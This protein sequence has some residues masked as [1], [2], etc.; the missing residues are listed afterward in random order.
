MTEETN[1]IV[2]D[3]GN[4]MTRAGFSGSE[5]PQFVTRS[6]IGTKNFKT[7]IGNDV[8]NNYGIYNIKHVFDKGPLCSVKTN[9]DLIPIIWEKVFHSLEANPAQHSV[10]IC[11]PPIFPKGDLEKTIE[12]MFETFN[13]PFYSSLDT[14]SLSLFTSGRSTG[15]VL[16]SGDL[17]TSFVPIYR[18]ELQFGSI[19]RIPLAGNE[20]TNYLSR[21]LMYQSFDFHTFK[22]MEIL[23]KIKEEHCFVAKD[24][25]YV[26]KENIECT[27]HDKIA[28]L[29][30][31]LYRCPELIFNPNFNGFR[32]DGFSKLLFDTINKVDE[33]VRKDLYA[34]IVLS[35]GN[36]MF[37]GFP[38]RIEKDIME[39]APPT[40]KI[41]CFATS[42]RLNY[43]WIGGSI[44]A[45]SPKSKYLFI[46]KDEYKDVGS[47][48][49]HRKNYNIF[50]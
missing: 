43:A 21:L 47:T 12:I 30:T 31:E 44:F 24:N 7:Y 11:V 20:V 18:G 40:M 26:S 33:D 32:Y 17:F 16:E 49:I 10:M 29:T 15:V 28:N 9:F 3:V 36:T 13:V 48:I 27:I 22:D 14:A 39:L 2:I 45:S 1:V 35:G 5:V 38:E 34:N 25:N 46:S 37:K 6:V 19:T 23:R 4:F 41:K 42:E 8:C 50:F